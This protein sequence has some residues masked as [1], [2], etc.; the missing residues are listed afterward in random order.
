MLIINTVVIVRGL[1]G[2]PD[3]DVAFALACFGGGSMVTALLLLRI[4]DNLLD[5]RVMLP[6]VRVLGVILLTLAARV[7]LGGASLRP[8]LLVTW[9][10]LGL[11]YSA[12]L[13]LTGRLLRRSAQPPDRPPLFAEG[14]GRR[15]AHVFV[16][17]DLHR[18]WPA[19][20]RA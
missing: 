7:W 13:T 8:V 10:V 20:E 4:L 2:R 16:I 15:Y 5:R 11:G 6:A 3:S 9:A 17:D 19:P 12:I 14:H 1:L 18:R